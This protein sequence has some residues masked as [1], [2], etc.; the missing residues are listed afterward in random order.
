LGCNVRILVTDRLFNHLKINTM[1]TIVRSLNSEN[2]FGEF[3]SLRE[4]KLRAKELIESN[5]V[6]NLLVC[7]ISNGIRKFLFSV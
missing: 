7:E 1:Y 6:L 5:T 2:T 4:A 3:N